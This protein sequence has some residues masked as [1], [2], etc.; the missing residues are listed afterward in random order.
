ME[1]T[2]HG[3]DK[4]HLSLMIKWSNLFGRLK[5][6]S[7]SNSYQARKDALP[8]NPEW[9]LQTQPISGQSVEAVWTTFWFEQCDESQYIHILTVRWFP[10][11][12]MVDLEWVLGPQLPTHKIFAISLI[13]VMRLNMGEYFVFLFPPLSACKIKWRVIQDT[14]YYSK[15]RKSAWEVDSFS[16]G[17]EAFRSI[18]IK[19][20]NALPWC[21]PGCQ[22]LSFL[23]SFVLICV[24]YL[25]TDI[26]L[27]FI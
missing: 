19:I 11:T 6:I 15:L 4:Y 9:S 23:F 10:D 27:L 24:S 17:Q 2:N 14:K 12:Y 18:K 8:P 21:C 7:N 16:R 25:V 20:I 26:A 22:G 3:H 1:T 5:V 13:R